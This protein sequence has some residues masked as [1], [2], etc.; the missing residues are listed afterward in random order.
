MKRE[1]NFEGRASCMLL[2]VIEYKFKLEYY[3]FNMLKVILML[4]Q[5]GITTEHEQKKM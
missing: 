5:E 4:F 1:Q 3:S 2:K